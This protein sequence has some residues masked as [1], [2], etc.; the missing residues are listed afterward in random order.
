[1]PLDNNLGAIQQFWIDE[2]QFLNF[3]ISGRN[4][5]RSLI[6]TRLIG[7]DRLERE[8]VDFFTKRPNEYFS[9]FDIYRI[10]Q[11]RHHKLLYMGDHY[12]VFRYYRQLIDRNQLSN[13]SGGFFDNKR[14]LIVYIAINLLGLISRKTADLIAVETPEIRPWK[15]A[16]KKI[17]EAIERISNNSKFPTMFW[18]TANTVGVKGDG[19][20]IPEVFTDDKGKEQVRIKRVMP[21]TWFPSLDPSAINNI[22]E[23]TFAWKVPAAGKPHILRRQIYGNGTIE[24]RANWLNGKLIGQPLT[25]D[26]I[27]SFI[28]DGLPADVKF[29]SINTPIVTHIPNLEFDEQH[30]F[31]ISDYVDVKSPMD[32]INH[33]LTQMSKELDKHGNLSMRG[34]QLGDKENIT[35]KYLEFFDKGVRPEYIELPTQSLEAMMKEVEML[36]KWVCVLMEMS[37][38]IL[39]LKEG[40]MPETASALKIQ[41]A[42]SVL[43]ANRKRLFLTNA[44]QDAFKY[45]MML[46]NEMEINKYKVDGIVGI[47]WQDGF[48]NSPKEDADLMDL[49]TGSKPTISVEDAVKRLDPDAAEDL[50]INLKAEDKEN[51]SKDPTATPPED[52]D[53]PDDNSKKPRKE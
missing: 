20:W 47:G 38:G 4:R 37:P 24:H 10:L 41:S 26:E 9:T 34:P 35:G 48:P 32:E 50:L 18:A 42:P 5:D 53:Q 2:H 1:M 31:G 49:R 30:P 7:T 19:I 40:S 17:D 8:S 33:R 21:E 13:R 51:E 27:N 15:K 52:K 6:T 14:K 28:P 44:L 11:Y 45:A 3:N 39:G 43:K 25:E 12:D 36:T 29:N 22:K 16:G 46:E 23:H